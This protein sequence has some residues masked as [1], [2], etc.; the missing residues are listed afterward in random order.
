MTLLPQTC[1]APL[2][3]F[4]EVLDE[5]IGFQETAVDHLER[6]AEAVVRLDE[7]ALREQMARLDAM[8]ARLADAAGRRHRARVRLAEALG[9]PVTEV[10]LGRLA[11]DLPEP[12]ASR[13]R[14]RRDRLRDLGEAVRRQHLRCAVRLGVA[15]RINRSL[16]AA[17]APGAD[18]P[19]TYATDGSRNP[20]AAQAVLDARL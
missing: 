7:S 20:A 4:V 14:L 6:L 11:G 13:I 15:A 10:T 9:R 8:P 17:M 1:D 18:A 19:Q 5:A 12:Q 3:A 2:E 16:L